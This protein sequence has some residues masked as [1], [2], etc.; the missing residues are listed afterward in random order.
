MKTIA[1][2]YENHY[3]N[4]TMVGEEKQI[5]YPNENFTSVI[6]IV[7]GLEASVKQEKERT[8]KKIAFTKFKA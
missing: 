8:K 6:E 7:H 3:P 5:K 2:K 1:K 4:L